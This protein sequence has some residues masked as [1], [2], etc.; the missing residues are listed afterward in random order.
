MK[1]ALAFASTLVLAVPLTISCNKGPKIKVERDISFNRDWSIKL[2]NDK[3]FKNID[4]PYDYSIIQTF[5]INNSEAEVGYTKGG[6][7]TYLKKFHL[8]NLNGKHMI[9]NF[10]GIYEYSKI[11]VNDNYVGE[12]LY[13]Y[14]SFAFDITNYVHSNDE[15]TIKVEV[16]SPIP[17]SR[18]YSGAGIYRNVKISYIDPVHIVRH[19][20]KIETP[21]IRYG[22]GTVNI[23][24]KIKNGS[25]DKKSIYVTNTIYDSNN[26]VVVEETRTRTTKFNSN[27]EVNLLNTLTVNN[28]LLWSDKNPN[29]YYV[30]TDVYSDSKLVDT[31]YSC[32]GFRYF[33]FNE[34]GF[35]LNGIPTKLKGVSMH[36]DQ[37]ALGANGYI[38][39]YRRQIRKLKGMGVNAI[40]TT[41]NMFDEE[42]IKLCDEEGILFM[43]EA[44]DM[45]KEHKHE[46][47][48][49]FARYFDT[50]LAKDNQ[51]INGGTN[52]TW[53]EFTLKEMVGR[54]I[55][56]PSI[57][58]WSIGNEISPS[59][60]HVETVKDLIK[61][62]QEVD[63]TRPVTMGDNGRTTNPDENAG[64]IVHA[65]HDA[66]GV[67]GYNY[68]RDDQ[69]E[70]AFEAFGSYYSSESVSALNSRG[71][72][73]GR[74]VKGDKPYDELG[75][76]A[77]PWQKDPL[78]DIY[79]FN[80]PSY[81]R[82]WASSTHN[83]NLKELLTKD[84][85]A[86]QFV[87]TG[88]DYIGEP[89]P[90][91]CNNKG[92]GPGPVIEGQIDQPN[93]SYFGI[94]DT[95]GF[96][97]DVY[98]LY[99]AQYR[100][101]ITTLNLVGSYNPANMFTS[102]LEG[103]LNGMTP[104]DIYTNAFTVKLYSMDVDSDTPKKE[105]LMA[106][107]SA[108]HHITSAGH[109]YLTYDN[110][111]KLK[112]EDNYKDKCK[113][114]TKD[115]VIKM[116]PH[117]TEYY[118]RGADLYAKFYIKPE[119]NKKLV[120]KAYDAMGKEI[121]TTDGLK[122]LVNPGE[123]AQINTNVDK[124]TLK[125]DNHSLSFIECTLEDNK[126]NYINT[127][128]TDDFEITLEGAGEIAGV[129]NGRQI[130]MKKFQQ[131]IST[132]KHKASIKDYAGKFLVIVKSTYNEGD[133]KLTIKSKGNISKEINLVSK[134]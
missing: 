112:I 27:E 58:L 68:P 16:D 87:W 126:G 74:T 22:R 43:E 108:D 38:D 40:R 86:G 48:Y 95:A 94:I 84:Y 93:T 118:A 46:N 92:Y 72:Y 90:W 41:H 54:D 50:K 101:D 34:R 127:E 51:V 8:D 56:N 123:F 114:F 15:N 18:Y 83:R 55:N 59:N 24:S 97:K 128:N 103:D 53:A 33:D 44:F 36:H 124:T 32:F 25:G 107:I 3:E 71:Q 131:T 14:N 19:G 47:V 7:A 80:I 77:D 42:Y 113:F 122:E 9:I 11:Y 85:V 78:K 96:A 60:A 28:P 31:M 111:D 39:S 64:K 82:S 21:E 125:S 20:V 69:E 91:N 76:S 13:G 106:S 29:L 73:K 105:D 61:W 6:K 65:I 2:E 120:A 116:D 52:K 121:K 67:V 89:T 63:T 12:N 102:E 10:D 66:G 134:K 75:R 119:A 115:E 45:W 130:E 62:V 57:I 35:V 26:N 1:K 5:D 99:Q 79:D 30:K 104:I 110:K 88:F 100:R 133:I 98:Y 117:F 17:S 81:D 132:D 129:D 49:D 4:L 23:Y 37:G 109:S 70:D